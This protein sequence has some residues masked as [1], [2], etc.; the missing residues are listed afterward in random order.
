MVKRRGSLGFSFEAGQCLRIFGDVFGEEFQR[1]EAVQSR[2]FGLVDDSH[3]TAAQALQDAVMRES[4]AVQRIR[5]G[6]LR[7]ILESGAR[8]VNGSI[9]GF[10]P[11]ITVPRRLCICS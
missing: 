9:F 10:L 1:N 11:A 4:S 3:S 6:H 7:S 5:A 8:A 2:I